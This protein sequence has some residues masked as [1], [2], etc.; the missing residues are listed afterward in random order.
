MYLGVC[1]FLSNVALYHQD[2]VFQFSCCR[3][4][5]LKKAKSKGYSMR[6][7]GMFFAIQIIVLF[8]KDIQMAYSL[9][10]D[11]KKHTPSYIHYGWILVAK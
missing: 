8:S 2:I 7:H 11:M 10:A 5:S 9:M 6:K 4:T 3:R 1:N